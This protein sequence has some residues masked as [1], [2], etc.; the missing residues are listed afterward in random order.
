MTGVSSSSKL[1]VGVLLS[2]RIIQRDKEK[3]W[4]ARGGKFLHVFS[5]I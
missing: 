3:G 2:Y 5:I 1:M 4:G